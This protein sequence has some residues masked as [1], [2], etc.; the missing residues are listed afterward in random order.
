M[1]LSRPVLRI[2]FAALLLAPVVL[3]YW[4]HFHPK[5][6]GVLP[7]GFIQYDQPYYMANARQYLDGAT[8]GLRYALPFSPSADARPIHFQPQT[9]LLAGLWRITGSDPGALFV[10]FGMVAALLCVL[11]ALRVLDLAVGTPSPPLL[12]LLFIWGG[13][14]IALT[15]LGFGLAHGQ[16]WRLAAWGAFRFDPGHGWWF[17]NLGRNL[18]FPLEAYYHALFFGMVLLIQRKQMV[19][20]ALMSALLAL[21]HPFTGVAGLLVLLTWGIWERLIHHAAAAS[22]VWLSAIVGFLLLLLAWHGLLLPVDGEHRSVMAQ[23]KLPWM[24]EAI[25]ALQAYAIVGFAAAAR[26]R[27]KERIK[28]F[29][30]RPMN[31]LLVAWAVVFLA[32]ENHELVMEPIQPAHF[33][34][35]Y[36]WTALFL[37]GAPA[38]LE[39]WN[40][41]KGR[42]L[43]W[44]VAL[45]VAA[46]LLLDNTAWFTMR[47][48]E[49]RNGVGDGIRISADH[50]DLY[51][52]LE[53]ELPEEELLVAED[54]IVAYLALV[55]THHRALYSHF[56]NTPFAQ[57]RAA[58]VVDYFNGRISDPLLEHGHIAIAM[59]GGRP[60]VWAE[61]GEQVFSNRAF[62]VYRMP[63]LTD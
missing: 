48:A 40:W 6:K 56:A 36:A 13:G 55:Y 24:V 16:G 38:L 21:S 11:L 20:A 18:I 9:V 15:G 58:S 12:A 44:G 43:R 30:A 1:P 3:F 54:P 46:L 5:N 4:A 31:R 61:R 63:R 32:L 29:L 2:L 59:N 23:W 33:T 37:I 39:G 27:S 22:M 26:L 25:S 45:A 10:A 7:T 50:V 14:L 60:F 34:R 51:Q 28:D 42:A 53:R 41:L 35:G 49:S 17:M 52:W 47:A 62:M 57:Q 19:A 8:D